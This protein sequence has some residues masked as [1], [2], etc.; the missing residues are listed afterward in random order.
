MDHSTS[1]RKAIC[2]HASRR[3]NLQANYEDFS[4]RDLP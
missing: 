1:G 3:G 4:P 2:E